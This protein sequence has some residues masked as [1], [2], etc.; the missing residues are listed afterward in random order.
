MKLLGIELID[1]KTFEKDETFM[2][3]LSEPTNGAKVG[4]L[5]RTVVTIVN[6][7]G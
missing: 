4:R 5:K 6:D 7:D 2:L 3:T 1:D